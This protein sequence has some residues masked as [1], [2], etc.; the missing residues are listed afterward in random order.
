MQGS[1]PARSHE[2]HPADIDGL[3]SHANSLRPSAD[4][5]E[6]LPPVA[7]DR[8]SVIRRY[9]QI[10]AGDV[11]SL[12]RECG[13]AGHHRPADAFSAVAGRNNNTRQAAGKMRPDHA[14]LNMPLDL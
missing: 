4:V 2:G 10:D 1:R 5:I 9:S 14:N 8:H 3:R 12:E 13:G 6:A 7:G 11:M